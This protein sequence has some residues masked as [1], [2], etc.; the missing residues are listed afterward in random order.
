MKI[1]KNVTAHYL[2]EKKRKIMPIAL[3]IKLQKQNTSSTKQSMHFT[4]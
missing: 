3:K 4:E 1:E 2:K